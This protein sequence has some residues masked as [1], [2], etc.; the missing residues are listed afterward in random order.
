MDVGGYTYELTL[1]GHN[2]ISG[3]FT[4]SAG[5]TTAITKTLQSVGGGEAG[6]AGMLFGII[7][8]AA[9]G[10]MM[11]AKEPTQEFSK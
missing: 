6:G 11:T 10:M 5:Q 4:I 2:T 1:P 7:G 3:I 9:P 8:I